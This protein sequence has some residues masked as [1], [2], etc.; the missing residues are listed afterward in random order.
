MDV[1][2]STLLLL[3]LVS[4]LAGFVDAIAGGGGLLTMPAL[5]MTGM[6]P[7]LV[8]G[9]NK[10]QGMFGS[11][12]AL[13]RYS[14]SPLLDKKRA[15]VSLL[16]ALG[17]AV[18]GVALVSSLSNE[19]L[20]PMVMVLLMGVALLLLIRRPQAPGTP[21]VE[22]PAWMAVAVAAVMGAYDGFFGPGTGTFLIMAYVT[23][24]KDPMDAASANAKVVN[25]ASNVAAL[26]SFAWAGAV[27]WKVALP[28]GLA[29][30]LGAQVGAHVTITRGHSL[31]RSAVI[32]VS[33]ALVARLGWQLYGTL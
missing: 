12:S 16:P 28:M 17:G 33:L 18:C 1:P 15:R 30:A 20:R 22:R 6:D 25:F 29:Q 19:V 2:L 11:G 10:G 7:R 26:A 9:T 24:W 5:L 4:L 14:K 23:L 3:M 21:R 31:V 8:L 32:L 13:W 27:L